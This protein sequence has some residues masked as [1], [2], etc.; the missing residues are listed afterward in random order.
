MRLQRHGTE[1]FLDASRLTLASGV[2]AEKSRGGRLSCVVVQLDARLQ[3]VG[4]VAKV[5]GPL[6]IGFWF[7]RLILTPSRLLFPQHCGQVK[8]R[9]VC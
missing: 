1:W 3:G 6:S 8:E 9:R 5:Q 2:L 4:M 7:S